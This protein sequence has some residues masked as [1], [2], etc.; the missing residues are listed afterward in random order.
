MVL[1]VLTLLRFLTKSSTMKVGKLILFFLLAFSA[2]SVFTQPNLEFRLPTY[3]VYNMS[4]GRFAITNLTTNK[5]IQPFDSAYALPKGKY[6][7]EVFVNS[8]NEWDTIVILKNKTITIDLSKAAFLTNDPEAFELSL[9]SKDTL[10]FSYWI[11]GCFGEAK[12]Y[13]GWICFDNRMNLYGKAID[14]R[15]SSDWKFS[16]NYSFLHELFYYSEHSEKWC[17]TNTELFYFSNRKRFL[18]FKGCLRS[19]VFNKVK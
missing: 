7:V 3:P 17:G 15:D 4:I 2:E 8:K 12:P 14:Q 10:F 1:S 13:V 16:A 6:K 18:I 11:A 19:F 9:D 5:L